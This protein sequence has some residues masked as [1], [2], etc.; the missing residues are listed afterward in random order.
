MA[1]PTAILM[2]TNHSP[3]NTLSVA[4]VVTVTAT[5]QVLVTINK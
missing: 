1:L 4:V 5:Q 2:F 3:L